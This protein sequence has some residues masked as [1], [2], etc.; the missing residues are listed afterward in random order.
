LL[1]QILDAECCHDLPA[2]VADAVFDYGMSSGIG[3]SGGVLWR[4][5]GLP[6]NTSGVNDS[7]AAAAVR[8]DAN[9]LVTMF[10]EG[11]LRVLKSLKTWGVLGNG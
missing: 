6:D 8:A 1:R 7:L 4:C 2:G 9:S 3:R 5:L 11:W 10:S